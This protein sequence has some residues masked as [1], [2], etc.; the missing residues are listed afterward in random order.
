[1][2][3][4]N[5]KLIIENKKNKNIEQNKI[6]MDPKY[7]NHMNEIKAL[8]ILHQKEMSKNDYFHNKK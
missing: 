8:S 1:M 2:G 6:L 3:N 4:S 7:N 5:E